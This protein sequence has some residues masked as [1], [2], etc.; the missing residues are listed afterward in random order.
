MSRLTIFLA[1]FIGLSA[2]ILVAGLVVKGTAIIQTATADVPVMF[3]FAVLSLAAG[4]A[5]I[6]GHN[7]W[8]GGVLTVVVTVVGWLIFA[9]GLMLL[10]LKPDAFAGLIQGMQVAEH[11]YVTLAPAF[12]IGL[13]L[14]VAGFTARTPPR[15]L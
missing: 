14:T 5:M 10:F 12:V 7:V 3:T 8:K 4:L 11:P 1:R 2:V 9:K 6:L 13:Y 15:E